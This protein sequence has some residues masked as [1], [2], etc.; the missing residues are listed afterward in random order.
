MYPG[1]ILDS[2]YPIDIASCAAARELTHTRKNNRVIGF[3]GKLISDND[4]WGAR[5]IGD[6]EERE[7]LWALSEIT[8][9]RR[10]SGLQR[11]PKHD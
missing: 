7:R 1:R 5:I 3:A 4:A 11:I 9:H 10:T 8:W 6:G 2:V